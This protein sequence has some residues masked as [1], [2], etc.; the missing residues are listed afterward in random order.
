MFTYWVKRGTGLFITS[1]LL[2]PSS[3]LIF[4]VLYAGKPTYDSPNP[5][6][7]L[8]SPCLWFSFPYSGSSV[9]IDI[10]SIFQFQ[11]QKYTFCRKYFYDSFKV[12]LIIEYPGHFPPTH[13]NITLCVFLP[14]VVLVC[15]LLEGLIYLYS[16]I[17]SSDQTKN[18]E[19]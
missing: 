4:S 6:N 9:R 18:I 17:L 16:L 11:Y 13:I 8:L 2:S 1:L 3:F 12:F 14:T 10:I 7:I 15:E 19:T 5:W